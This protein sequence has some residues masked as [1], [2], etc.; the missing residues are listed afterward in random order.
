MIV[1]IPR[2]IADKTTL[3]IGDTML[4]FTDGDK[5]AITRPE[6]PK[7]WKIRNIDITLGLQDQQIESFLLIW[8]QM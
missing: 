8:I 5:I 4:M 2:S 7:L 6:M 1:S 3:E